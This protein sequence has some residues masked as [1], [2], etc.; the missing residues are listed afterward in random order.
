MGVAE[1][2]DALRI[3]LTVHHEVGGHG[4]APGATMALADEL[5]ARGHLVDV[6]GLGILDRARGGTVD[7]LRFPHAVSALVRRRLDA[8]DCDVVDASS[9]DLAYVGV[10]S[11][12]ASSTAVFARSHGLEHLGVARRRQGARDGE[13]ALRRRYRAYHGG[14]RLWE[15]A[16]SLRAADGA[17]LLNASEVQFA[18]KSL[19][20][21]SERVWLTAPVVRSLPEVSRAPLR[22]VLVLGPCSWRKGG[23][24][25]V[26][27]LDALL[28]ADR[29]TTAS[30]WGL[31]EPS[32]TAEELSA[33]VRDRVELG[34]PYDAP[35]LVELLASHRALLFPSR[36]E[37]LPVTLLEAAGAR[38]PVVG[39]DVP[40][41]RDV[42]GGGAGIL[43]PDGHVDGMV[44][45][46]RRLLRDDAALAACG[47]RGSDVAQR[48]APG[49]VVDELVAAYRT[50]LAVKRPRSG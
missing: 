17:L 26:R 2:G 47:A 23:D 41:V 12:R 14:L 38:L 31:D 50:V 46:L 4:G 48:F 29:A 21:A 45:A 3:L 20:L 36:F 1:G 5:S 15:V 10:R 7:A 44:A 24:L 6:V 39:S 25:S 34:G 30:W 9:G 42:L 37:G 8:G 32:I 28:R 43:V 40:G 18:T 11:V 49:H 33:D 27:V 13:L 16:R 22:D 19:H 35:R